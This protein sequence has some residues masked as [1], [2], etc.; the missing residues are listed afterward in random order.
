[1]IAGLDRG[2]ARADFHHHAGAFVA[3]DRRKQPLGIGATER[4]LVGVA[5]AGRLDLDHHLAGARA[6]KVDLHNLQR[7]A[8]G[9]RHRGIV[10]A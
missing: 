1:M 6:V 9:R 4:E 3:E 8:G 10:C 5:N 7:L 2:H